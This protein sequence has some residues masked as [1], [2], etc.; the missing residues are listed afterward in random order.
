MPTVRALEWLVLL[1]VTSPSPLHAG[2]LPPDFRHPP[3]SARRAVH[4]LSRLA[5]GCEPPLARCTHAL[6]LSPSRDPNPSYLGDD[7]IRCDKEE[8][9][10]AG[11]P[12]KFDEATKHCVIPAIGGVDAVWDDSSAAEG[13]DGTVERF[14]HATC[15]Q[16][17]RCGSG[18]C[19]IRAWKK[20]TVGVPQCDA[21]WYCLKTKMR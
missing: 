16:V 14:T 10:C 20:Y 11:A 8:C 17:E 4:T 9:A 7:V 21:M 1:L 2:L 6:A 15:D 19:T 13:T 3:L 12:A 18:L 5:E